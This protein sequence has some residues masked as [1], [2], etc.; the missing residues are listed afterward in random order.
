M[1][2]TILQLSTAY[3]DHNPLK[4]PTSWAVDAGAV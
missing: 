4:I 1:G 2:D 3:T